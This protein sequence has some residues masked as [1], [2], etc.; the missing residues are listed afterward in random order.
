MRTTAFL[1]TPRKGML[2]LGFLSGTIASEGN[3]INAAG[4]RRG[5]LWTIK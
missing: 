1:W 4:F 2:D 3:A 5:T